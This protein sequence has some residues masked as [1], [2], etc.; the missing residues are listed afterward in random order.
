MSTFQRVAVVLPPKA[1]RGDWFIGTLH[2]I[3][4]DA[5]HDLGIETFE[6]P[7]EAF[8]SRDA[9]A[10]ADITASLRAF[11]PQ[12][13][14]ALTL[15][16]L[17]L[18]C[19]QRAEGWDGE[20]NL[21]TDILDIP[22]ICIWDHAP[23]DF[24]V[25]L[26]GQCPSPRASHPGALARLRRVLAHPRMIHWSRDSGQTVLMRQLDLVDSRR[27]IGAMPPTLPPFIRERDAQTATEDVAFVGFVHQSLPEW[28]DAGLTALGNEVTNDWLTDFDPPLWHSLTRRMAERS[29]ARRERLALDPDQTYF[30]TYV[31]RLI[32]QQ[33]Q[34]ALRLK[35]LGAAGVPV[36]VYGNLQPEGAPANLRA[37][38]SYVSY[39]PP[40]AQVF[41]RHAITIDVIS[42][43][44]HNGTGHKPFLAFTSGGFALLNRKRDFVAALGELGDA[45]SFSS[46]DELAAKVDLYLSRPKLRLELAAAIREKIIA[47]RPLHGIL[48]GILERAA[49]IPTEPTSA[50]VPA[51][52]ISSIDLLPT[53]RRWGRWP[54]EPSRMQR[55]GE[56]VAVGCHARDWGYAAQIVLPPKVAQMREPYLRLTLT[57]KRGRIGVGML[58]DVAVGSDA[59]Q[60]VGPSAVPVTLLVKLPRD[61]GATVILRKT[62]DEPASAFVT[63]AL[64]RDRH[65]YRNA[66]A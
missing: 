44:F 11:K 60:H 40:L 37:V 25:R 59:E 16:F 1:W 39:G 33:A 7:H 63:E 43:S 15:G 10:P 36:A 47:E 8:A 52:P 42:P 12:A 6:V 4:C 24:A 49:A 2:S 18:D 53:L 55:T 21:F 5:L 23:L 22:T 9:A 29:P 30:W 58:Q 46:A 31:Q 66:A 26:L 62:S 61:P 27:V 3:Y 35:L 48:A 50:A 17:L 34:N 41:A 20:P 13:A 45:V 28:P 64:L 54:W 38:A 51:E 56:G 14:I 32:T 57:T 65:A 19:R